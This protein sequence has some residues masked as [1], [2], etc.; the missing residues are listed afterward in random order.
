[1]CF[2]VFVFVFVS[3]TFFLWSSHW[4]EVV[5]CFTYFCAPIGFESKRDNSQKFVICFNFAKPL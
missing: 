3:G 2:F 4:L 5:M 1:M